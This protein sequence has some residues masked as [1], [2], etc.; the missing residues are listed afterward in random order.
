MTTTDYL[1]CG[2]R[3]RSDLPLPELLAW[4]ATQD[5][6]PDITIMQ[7]SVPDRLENAVTQGDSFAVDAQ[8]SALLHIKGLVRIL[9]R[10]GRQISVEILRRESSESWRLFLLGSTLGHIAHQRGLFPLHAA[11]LRVK[12]RTIAI[13]GASGAGKSTMA[14]ALA[15]RGH[16][17]LSDD[18]IVVRQDGFA[19]PQVLPAFPRLKLWRDTLDTLAVD[20]R[21]LPR[22]RDGM[23]KFN[24]AGAGNFGFDPAPRVLDAIFVLD[25]QPVA[26]LT[27]LPLLESA[28]AI[29]NQIFRPKFGALL[30]NAHQ[31]RLFAQSV[32]IASK[33]RVCRLERPKIFADL[34][35]IVTL[36]EDHV[37]A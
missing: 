3:V 21:M 15:Q 33:T 34:A 22:V 30:G 31:A 6:P 29:R 28:A 13:A 18:L 7:A 37:A 17:L 8:G 2:W 12:E 5:I 11:C 4:P 35:A 36:V 20:T 32:A 16:A 1:L 24:L 9:A 25:E 23:E 26:R 19:P 27:P 14:M 10:G